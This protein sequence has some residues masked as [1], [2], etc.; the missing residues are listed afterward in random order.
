MH[1][2]ALKKTGIIPAHTLP[3]IFTGNFVNKIFFF[4]PKIA[5]KTIKNV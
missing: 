5:K 3:I 1:F 2:K 4:S